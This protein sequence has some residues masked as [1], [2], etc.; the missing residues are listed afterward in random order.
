[1]EVPTESQDP[2]S[3]QLDSWPQPLLFA[4]VPSTPCVPATS[5][6]LHRNLQLVPIGSVCT[7]LFLATTSDY[8]PYSPGIGPESTTEEPRAIIPTVDSPQCS[9][10]TTV[11]SAPDSR[12]LSHW[13]MMAP[14]SR[15]TINTCTW[16]PDTRL[17]ATSSCSIPP[18][19]K[20]GLFLPKSVHKVW[21]NWLFLK[22]C[23]HLPMQGYWH[24]EE[25]GNHAITKGTQ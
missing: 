3:C 17:R 12:R 6:S 9:P 22:M 10:K 15:A 25:S 24:H 13:D 2:C 4:L 16:C 7:P 19:H 8:P 11:V 18:S 1:M 20:L 21:K 23:R 5:P 14:G